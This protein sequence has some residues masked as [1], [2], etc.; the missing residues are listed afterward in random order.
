MIGYYSDM[1]SMLLL[2]QTVDTELD[3]IELYNFLLIFLGIILL[4]I[5]LIYILLTSKEE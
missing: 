1:V 5:I 3:P 2:L 4:L